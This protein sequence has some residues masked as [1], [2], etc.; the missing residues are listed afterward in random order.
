MSD[1]WRIQNPNTLGTTWSNG[2]KD[3][4]KRVQTRIDRVLVDN[5]IK[6]RITDTKHI[7]TKV[8]DHNAVVWRIETE[9]KR[10]TSP[11]NKMN[12]EIIKDEKFKEIVKQHYD[13][14]R[15]NGIEGYER[16]KVKCVESALKLNKRHKKK[17]KKD[18][19]TVNN[20]LELMRRL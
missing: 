7:S 4:N 20:E 1:I 19:T 5:K 17:E 15:N 12:T 10:K 13:N 18:K 16:F 3:I 6:D 2:T 11:Y 9:I 8:S 14:E